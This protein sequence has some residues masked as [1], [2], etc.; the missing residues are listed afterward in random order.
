MVVTVCLASFFVSSLNT[1]LHKPNKRLINYILISKFI[2]ASPAFLGTA[3]ALQAHLL[4]NQLIFGVIY[5]D[6]SNVMYNYINII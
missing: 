6:E 3:S 2:I 4:P 1:K 5:R